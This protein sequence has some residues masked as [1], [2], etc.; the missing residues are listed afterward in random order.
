MASH[1][2]HAGH[3]MTELSMHIGIKLIDHPLIASHN[4]DEARATNEF[5]TTRSDGLAV[6]G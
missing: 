3:T 6:D 2:G 1:T 4:L 5:L